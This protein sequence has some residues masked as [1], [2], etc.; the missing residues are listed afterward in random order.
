MDVLFKWMFYTIP[1]YYFSETGQCANG[2]GR[3]SHSVDS[4]GGGFEDVFLAVAEGHVISAFQFGSGAI[5][6]VSVDGH[7]GLSVQILHPKRPRFRVVFDHRMLRLYAVILQT[8]TLPSSFFLLSPSS[9]IIRPQS[10][11]LFLPAI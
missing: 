3:E 11:F 9:F 6:D 1:E 10:S 7:S 8:S 5:K 2:G 4:G